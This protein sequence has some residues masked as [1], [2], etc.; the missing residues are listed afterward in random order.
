[1]FA[2]APPDLATAIL[3]SKAMSLVER[4]PESATAAE[5]LVVTLANQL[6]GRKDEAGNKISFYITSVPKSTVSQGLF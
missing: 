6:R 2:K 1:M 3:T 4:I 5:A